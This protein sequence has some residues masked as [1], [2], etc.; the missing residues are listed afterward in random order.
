MARK[1]I[2][3]VSTMVL[4]LP[5]VEGGAI[6]RLITM[7]IEQNEKYGLVDLVVISIYNEKAR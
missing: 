4:P 6:E 7:L 1:K 5:D 2:F 3:L